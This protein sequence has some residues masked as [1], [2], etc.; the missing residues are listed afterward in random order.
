MRI[1]GGQF[2]SRRLHAPPEDVKTR[3]ITDRVKEAVFNRLMAAGRLGG[4]A[5]LDVFA[6]TG[7]LGLEALS[8]GSDTATFIERNRIAARLLERN[9]EQLGVGKRCD[10]LRVDALN[11]PWWLQLRRKRLALAFCDPPYATVQARGGAHRIIKLL[12]RITRLLEPD[13]AIV[14]RLP[15]EI[16]PLEI[17]GLVV[18]EHFPFGSM[19][20]VWYEAAVLTPDTAAAP[21]QHA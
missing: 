20:V 13:G 10:V 16:E 19:R 15:R 8:R 18:I 11:T 17:A 2:K 1:I 14:L 21:D 7:S 6:G 9:I 4:G 5:V 3:P 12:E